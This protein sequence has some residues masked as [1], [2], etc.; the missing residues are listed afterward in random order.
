MKANAGRFTLIELLVVI[1][2]I[3]ILASLLLP[4][5]ARA[6]EYAK[7]SNCKN[8]LKQIGIVTMSYTDDYSGWLYGYMASGRMWVRK[9]LGELFRSG[10][11]NTVNAKILLCPSDKSPFLADGASVNSSY[12]LNLD[13]CSSGATA[14]RSLNR[15]RAHSQTMLMVDTQNANNGDATPVRISEQTN[16]R[17]HIYAG[18]QRHSKTLNM[19][20]LDTHVEDMRDP[21][22]N[23]PTTTTNR[24]FWY[25]LL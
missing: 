5:L 3:A 1:A 12:G 19:L 22:N 13:V 8:N 20:F 7:I 6:R 2:I 10:H 15:Q 17:Y 23:L 16:H 4:S 14:N 11:L 25:G 24:I 21:I 9:D 18:A